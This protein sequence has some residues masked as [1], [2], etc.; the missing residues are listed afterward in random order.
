MTKLNI[1][2]I[3]ILWLFISC[4][5]TQESKMA[6]GGPYMQ[7]EIKEDTKIRILD[8]ANKEMVKEGFHLKDFITEISQDS[9]SF[10]VNY[11]LKGSATLGG[12]GTIIISKDKFEVI[13]KKFYQ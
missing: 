4:S 3:T 9:I 11:V 10:I 7:A 2:I 12:G 1:F 6:N 13:N 5:T 8:I